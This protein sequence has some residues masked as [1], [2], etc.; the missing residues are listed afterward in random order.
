MVFSKYYMFRCPAH[1]WTVIFVTGLHREVAIEVDW[2]VLML[3]Y[4]STTYLGKRERP[5]IQF[6]GTSLK[7]GE[8][9]GKFA[10]C[11]HKGKKLSAGF[12]F[13]FKLV[14]ENCVSYML[15]MRSPHFKRGVAS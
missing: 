9:P 3:C 4:Y 11:H 5:D 12:S 6:F 1:L 2:C 15:E 13:T 7:V 8:H 14:P 10:H